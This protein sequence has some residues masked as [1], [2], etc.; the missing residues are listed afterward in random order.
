MVALS[1]FLLVFVSRFPDIVIRAIYIGF[2]RVMLSSFEALFIS[3]LCFWRS[4]HVLCFLK[5]V[6][7]RLRFN[8]TRR[9]IGQRVYGGQSTYIPFKINPCGRFACYFVSFSSFGATILLQQVFDR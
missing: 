2:K 3:Y 8:D 4:L 6:T 1:S 9:V 5:K 7:A